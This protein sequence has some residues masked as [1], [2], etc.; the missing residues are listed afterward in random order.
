M[1]VI[2]YSNSYYNISNMDQWN[3]NKIR[4]NARQRKA[5]KQLI[6]IGTYLTTSEFKFPT[7]WKTYNQIANESI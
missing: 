2:L 3:H 4:K 7:P 6:N 5:T 1:K